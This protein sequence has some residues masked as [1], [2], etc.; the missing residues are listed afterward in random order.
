MSEIT[1]KTV[2]TITVPPVFDLPEQNTYGAQ[3]QVLT[4]NTEQVKQLRE[5]LNRILGGV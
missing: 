4:V 5:A 3:N 2:H 1:V